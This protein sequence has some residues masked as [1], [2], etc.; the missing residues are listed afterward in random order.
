MPKQAKSTKAGH[1]HRHLNE[2]STFTFPGS[3]DGSHEFT[4]LVMAVRASESLKG[5]LGLLDLTLERFGDLLSATPQ[6][7]RTH[8]HVSKPY[9][10]MLCAGKRFVSPR[11]VKAIEVVIGQQL[12]EIAGEP[13]GLRIT[14]NSP[15]HFSIG[16]FC[17]KHGPYEIDGRRRRCP[18]CRKG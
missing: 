7:T 15:W 17:E 9:A 11:M 16:K 10:S 4:T 12:T 18:Q 6:L 8:T 3:P 1:S 14:R 2:S 5:V 13:I